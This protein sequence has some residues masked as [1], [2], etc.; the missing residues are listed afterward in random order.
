ML[1]QIDD[2]QLAAWYSDAA[3]RFAAALV[4]SGDRDVATLYN[5]A[6]AILMAEIVLVLPREPLPNNKTAI[7]D[8]DEKNDENDDNN[9]DDDDDA[10]PPPVKDDGKRSILTAS[11]ATSLT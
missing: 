3:Q 1:L 9:D 8:D 6:H 4:H 2:A 5:Q 10:E 7:D 11:D